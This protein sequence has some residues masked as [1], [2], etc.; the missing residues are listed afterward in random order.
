M[1]NT[2]WPVAST[3]HPCGAPMGTA[4]RRVGLAWLL[5]GASLPNSAL[6]VDGWVRVTGG[7]VV[8]FRHALAPGGGDPPGHKLDDCST[9][10]NLSDE[11][12]A[13]A[14]RIGAEFTVQKIEVAAVWSSQWCRT[15]D[16]ADLAFPGRRLDQPEFNSF[17]TAYHA[18]QAQTHAAQK[19]LAGW[20]GPGVLVVFTHQVNITALTNIVPASGEG[21]VV[22]PV[23]GR[24]QVLGRVMP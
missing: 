23:A 2:L 11:G 24:L 6:A 1:P 21:I 10:R 14:R 19:L 3:A 4:V 9:Q 15:R 20:R 16:T 17:F 22:K 18:A 5:L 8:L 7:T 12:R 13:Q